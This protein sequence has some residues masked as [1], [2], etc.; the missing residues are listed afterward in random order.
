MKKIE[1]KNVINAMMKER[2]FMYEKKN[3]WQLILGCDSEST[4]K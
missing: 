4:D 3:F 2:N 1:L